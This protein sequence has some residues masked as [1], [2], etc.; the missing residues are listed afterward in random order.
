MAAA[1]AALAAVAAHAEPFAEFSTQ[2]LPGSG[3]LAVHLRRPAAWKAVPADDPQVLAEFRGPEAPLTGILQIGRG[4]RRDDM[5]TL[6]EPGRARTMLQDVATREPG[7]RV[8]DVFARRIEGRAAYEL[9]YERSDAPGFLAVRT[10]IVCLKDTRLVVSCAG[11]A[12]RKTA[13]AAIEPL[14][15]QVL[16]SLSVTEE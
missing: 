16:E 3:G 4:Q 8:T 2:G 5:A 10:V 7:T 14:C 1:A 11:A 9:R 6:C 13:L 15:R 12:P